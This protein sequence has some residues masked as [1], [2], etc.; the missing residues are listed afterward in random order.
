MITS[1]LVI[2][3][4]HTHSNPSGSNVLISEVFYDTPGT[5]SA[6]EWIELYNPT[7]N[8]IFMSGWTV[9]DNA[10]TTTIPD[11]TIPA[12]GYFVFARSLTGFFNLYGF[13]PDSDLLTRS[14]N[15]AGDQLTLKDN[16]GAEVDFVAWEGGYN[17]LYPTWNLGNAVDV[18]IRRVMDGFGLPVDTDSPS[19]WEIAPDIGSPGSGYGTPPPA[20]SPLNVKVFFNDP[21]AGL[22]S[23]DNPAVQEGNLT[24]GLVSLINSANT[25]IDAALYHLSHQPIIDALNVAVQRGVTVRIA[26][27]NQGDASDKYDQLVGVQ[28]TDVITSAIMHNKFF[29]V[30]SHIVFTG[31]ANPTETG[32]NH[33]AN[34]AVQVTSTEVATQ[35][36]KEFDLLFQNIRGK[37]KCSG[38]SCDSA[39]VENGKI[40]VYFSPE[41]GDNGYSRFIEL[42]N[43]ATSTI[44][45]SIFYMTDDGIY[46]ALVA[47]RDRGVQI[48]AVFDYRGW[49]NS[50]SEA[51][52]VIGWGIGAGVVDANPGVLHH[53]FAV[54]DGQIVWVGSTNWSS[55][56]FND[57]DENAM[58]IHDASVAAHFVSRTDEYYND[59]VNYDNSATQAPRIVTHHYSGYLYENFITWRARMNGNLPSGDL[60]KSYLIWRWNPSISNWELLKELNWANDYYSDAN[61]TYDQMY[62]YCVSSVAWSGYQSGC[63]SEFGEMINSSDGTGTQDVIL[64]PTGR[65]PYF[66]SDTDAPIVSIQNPAD[67]ATVSGFVD[68]NIQT[69]DVSFVDDFKVYVDG[70]LQGSSD[71]VNIDTTSLS[72]GQHTILAEATDFFGNT[73]SQSITV[74]VDN[75]GYIAPL[76]DYN[77]VKIM[78]YN[79]EESGLN[80]QY[81][82][83]LK[84]EN[85]DVIILV[86]TGFLSNEANRGLNEMV[87]E[88]NNYF[89]S[90]ELPYHL[91][92]T[93]GQSNKYTGSAILSRFP[94]NSYDLI[95]IVTLDDG[96]Q[97]EVTHDFLHANVA[98]GTNN[99]D[100]IATHLK[101][102]SGATNEFRRER[103]I[104]GIMNYVD[105]LGVSAN[106]IVLGDF[107]SQPD[108]AIDIANQGTGADLGYNI[109]Q[110]FTNTSNPYVSAVDTW[111][112]AFRTINPTEVGHTYYTAPYESRIDWIFM[113]QGFTG[114]Y[115]TSTIGDTA[116][117]PLGSDH[118]D[119]DVTF[120][121]SA[122]SPYDTTA[123]AQVTGLAAVAVSTSQIDLSWN[124]NS[125]PDLDHYNIYRDGGFV[126]S[127]TATSFSDTGLAESTSYTYTVS[128]VDTSG[129]EGTAS[130]PV[131]QTTLTSQGGSDTVVISEV[132]YDTPGSDNQRE[133]VELF[134]YGS[135]TVDLSGWT[136]SDNVGTWTIP[137]GVT[138]APGQYLVIARSSS[139]FQSFYGFAPDVGG[140][141]LALGNNGDQ[142]TLAN[143]VGTTIDFVAWENYATGWNITAKTGSSI[144]RINPYVDSDTVAD[145]EVIG[146]N[147]TPGTQ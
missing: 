8:A 48:K 56:G 110:V 72:N 95:P 44:H 7:G 67:L 64:T 120:D 139:G 10:G 47:A 53:K 74:T 89:G 59:A 55:S 39:I 111:I 71:L 36:Q 94:I 11:F 131:S 121:L 50:Y 61:I 124:T 80:S 130:T 58:V 129:N 65:Q 146:N 123:P 100:L 99:V 69:N 147:G 31:S 113:N 137:Q 85:A 141:T 108:T 79:I 92:S 26:R 32:F 9:S 45:I 91:I 70:I 136:L 96:S 107:N 142:L 78:S 54:F 125:E 119:V 62:Y 38:T 84:E 75:T 27:D 102:T 28:I 29:I 42:I 90:S 12:G 133:W 43:N 106:V 115:T 112:D 41:S 83:V 51:D 132:F 30:D 117:A 104:E 127:T 93:F 19:D 1:V 13:N 98:I 37:S 34:D 25:S 122:W 52:D 87:V 14:L 103:E 105:T 22:P 128:A 77:N 143:S 2:Q 3:P 17:G 144:R 114:L 49:L 6:E 60:I 33:N 68:V 86:E 35:Y 24:S 4:I 101:A 82:D 140:M 66:G 116:S 109:Y 5:E 81:K 15:N 23:F 145:W 88:L 126:T 46:N 73:G 118:Y 135:T 97:Y 18:T 20:P 138:I 134:N 16:L 63:S 21:L 76:I 57:N 40:E